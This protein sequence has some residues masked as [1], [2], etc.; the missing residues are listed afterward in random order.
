[1]KNKFR[2]TL[3]SIICSIPI[4]VAS[5][6]PQ[7]AKGQDIWLSAFPL[8]KEPI[9]LFLPQ[10]V[11]SYDAFK[12]KVERDNYIETSRANDITPNIPTG[13]HT[14]NNI[15]YGFACVQASMLFE[16]NSHDWKDLYVSDKK[17]CGW[18][19]GEILDSIYVHAGTTKFWASHIA[20]VHTADVSPSHQMN[21][22][23]TGDDLS[24]NSIN[25][26]ET[27]YQVSKSN[28]K[29]GELGIPLNIASSIAANTE[30]YQFRIFDINNQLI[31][32]T[33][34][35]INNFNYSKLNANR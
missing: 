5:L 19:A 22:A 20:P 31:K 28:V 10:E 17:A 15:L 6:I 4:V 16:Y 35:I 34:L 11:S 27:M 25:F 21:Y 3:D 1:M 29:P 24:G 8:P 2:K 12:T 32:D 26:V 9:N 18:Y 14:V 30:K 13:L 23:V 33:T 7:N